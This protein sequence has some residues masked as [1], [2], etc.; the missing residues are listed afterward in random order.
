MQLDVDVS[1]PASAI[2]R[3]WC[4]WEM[5]SN[6]LQMYHTVC[7]ACTYTS[8]DLGDFLMRVYELFSSLNFCLTDLRMHRQTD[9]LTDRQRESDA[10]EPTA[11]NTGVLKTVQSPFAELWVLPEALSV[12]VSDEYTAAQNH[13]P[14]MVATFVYT[15][16]PQDHAGSRAC[17]DS[18]SWHSIPYPTINGFRSFADW[19]T[20]FKLVYNRLISLGHC[21]KTLKWARL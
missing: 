17:L 12:W 11:I 3:Y 1:P 6:C 19:I 18:K 4:N 8:W 10:Y 2:H 13:Q 20:G 16:W 7:Y 14:I 15:S 21:I 5:A 9:G